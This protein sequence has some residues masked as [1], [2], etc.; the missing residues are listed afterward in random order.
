MTHLH[1][2]SYAPMFRLKDECGREVSLADLKGSKVA[3]FFYPKDLTPG[4]TAQACNIRDNYQLLLDR[5]IYVVGVSADTEKSHARFTQKHELPF[6]LIADTEKEL[7][8]AYGVWGPKKFMGRE[9]DG[10]HRT[11]FLIS[12]TGVI[13]EIIEKVQTKNHVQQ[14]L[15][16]LSL[17]E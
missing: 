11:T 6:P 3:L 2:G 13:E 17:K 12:E 7:I 15:E 10:I 4:C 1:K 14:I 8:R 16:I 9:F 5:N